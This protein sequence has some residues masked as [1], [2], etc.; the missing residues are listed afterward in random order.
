MRNEYEIKYEVKNNKQINEQE[1][2]T[3]IKS[4]LEMREKSYCPYSNYAVGA[5][6]MSTD[7]KIYTGCNIE[8]SS[9]PAGICAERTALFKAVA[10]GKRDFKALAVCG[11]KQGE[12]PTDFAYPCGICRQALGEFCDKNFKVI[13]AVSENNYKILDF[14]ELLPYSFELS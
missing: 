12:D 8:N 4:A 10:D 7:G 13:V 6:I 1:L 14:G 5:A 9:F 3:L 11:G 2:H